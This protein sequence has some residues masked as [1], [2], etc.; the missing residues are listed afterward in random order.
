[1]S[2]TVACFCGNLYTAP[3]TRCDVCN[4][5]LSRAITDGPGAVVPVLKVENGLITEELGLGDGVTVLQQLGLITE[6]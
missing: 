1:M 2:W 3:P 5:T 6:A 4:R